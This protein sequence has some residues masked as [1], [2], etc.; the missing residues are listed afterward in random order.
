M[1]KILFLFVFL[2]VFLFSQQ[3]ISTLQKAPGLGYTIWTKASGTQ[4]YMLFTTALDTS[5]IY[6]YIDSLFNLV[7]GQNGIISA[8]PLGSV[9]IE[10]LQGASFQIDSLNLYQ[11]QS[12]S[13]AG[14]AQSRFFQ[15]ASASLPTIIEV[16]SPTDTNLIAKILLDS[17]GQSNFISNDLALRTKNASGQ[18]NFFLNAFSSA[19]PYIT[20]FDSTGFGVKFYDKYQLPNDTPSDGDVLVFYADGHSEFSAF[21]SGVNIYNSDGTQTDA[22]RNYD[23]NGGTLNFQ[24]LLDMEMT[25]TGRIRMRSNNNGISV[26]GG[27]TSLQLAIFQNLPA[28]VVDSRA[29]KTGLEYAADYC[30]TFTTRSL[31]DKG[32]AQSLINA[33]NLWGMKAD[34]G[35]AQDVFAGDQVELRGL[36]GINTGVGAT[37]LWTIEVDTTEIATQYDLSQL[38]NNIYTGDGTIADVNRT[39]TILD[40]LNF[41]DG[42]FGLSINSGNTNATLGVTGANGTQFFLNAD[43]NEI[44]FRG[45]NATATT[46]RLLEGTTNGTNF[47][48]IKSPNSLSANYTLTLPAANG[49]GDLRNDGSG[50]LSWGST[51]GTVISQAY[52]TTTTAGGQVTIVLPGTPSAGNCSCTGKTTTGNPMRY[53]YS[54]NYTGGTGATVGVY[55]GLLGQACNTCAVNFQVIC[56]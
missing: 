9:N 3:S 27:A 34:A 52:N 14:T 36:R 51:S 16:V 25:G 18:I 22:T 7:S 24:D 31:I 28:L 1:K 55:D 53:I 45:T 30:S 26:G 29:T 15:S 10:A 17:D 33:T 20:V 40:A 2:P 6:D 8:L 35:T 39:V 37:D 41:T 19:S 49:A 5:G 44:D 4:Q 42:N 54:I 38:G 56:N 21:P 13:N 46:L 47:V 48:G 23:A 11:V 43:N 50:N 32:C 12:R